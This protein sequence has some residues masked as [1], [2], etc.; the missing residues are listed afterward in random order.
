[1]PQPDDIDDMAETTANEA[2]A[3]TFNCPDVRLPGRCNLQPR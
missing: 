3:R 2:L 1:M